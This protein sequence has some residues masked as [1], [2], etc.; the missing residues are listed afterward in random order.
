MTGLPLSSLELA[1][2]M[3][4]GEPGAVDP[5]PTATGRSAACVLEALERELLPALRRPPCL[6]SFSGGRDSSAVLAVAAAVAR[7]EGLELPIPAT[8]RFR[9]AP[10]AA[11]GEWQAK[12][13]SHL[14]LSE[15]LRIE[16]SDE[17]DLIGPY[18]QRVLRTVGLVWPPNVHFHLP[19]LDAARGGSLVTGIGGDELF[20]AARRMRAVA[21]LAR[22]VR[23]R[24]RDLLAVPFAFAPVRVRRA[25]IER[26]TPIEAPWLR[27]RAL[28]LVRAIDAAETASEPR[29]LAERMA[30]WRGLRYLRVAIAPLDALAAAGDVQVRHP[31]FG[32]ELWGA[33]AS[34]AAPHGFAGR[35][36]AMR[37]L[38]GELLPDEIL[39]RRSKA[40]FDEAFWNQRSRA[41]ALAWDGTGVPEEWVDR[42]ALAQHWRGEHPAAQSFTLLQAAWLASRRA[43]HVEQQLEPVTG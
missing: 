29:R 41:F 28:R 27:D 31:L 9:S 38:F 21:V 2:G 20:A 14:G 10:S 4:L 3:V 7:R 36:S 19:L 1:A 42:D 30:W 32:R 37:L 22:L 11:E 16:H 39:A 15:W 13:V 25:V 35:S 40:H 6:V 23:P 33:V 5:L 43:G 17:L 18:A 26:R 34:L 24:P 12:V 8:N